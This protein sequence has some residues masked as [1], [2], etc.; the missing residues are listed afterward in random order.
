MLDPKPWKLDAV[1]RL[2][3]SVFICIFAGSLLIGVVHFAHH[4]SKGGL[5]F[6]PAVVVAFGFLAAT[7]VLIR[8]RWTLD[9]FMRRMT[10]LLVCF[11]AGLFLGMWAQQLA[12]PVRPDVPTS[13]QMLVTVLS[14][15]GAAILFIG[16]FLREHQTSWSEGFGLHHEPMKALLLGILAASLFLPLGWRLQTASADWIEWV[17]RHLHS[18]L[19]NLPLK[20]Q[21]Q[22]PVQT[23]RS[24]SSW[25]A[26]IALGVVTIFLVPVAEEILFRGIIYPWIKQRGH[27]RLA[28]VGTSVLFAAM[29]LNLVTFIPLFALAVVLTFLYEWTNNLLAPI[30]AHALFNGLNF[31]V[32]FIVESHPLGK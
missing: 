11:Y 26:R 3:I 27:P 21:E 17:S 18:A 22:L 13:G 20:V 6:Y 16:L 8:R 10:A 24:A 29:H 15:Q 1:V 5:K 4:G 32:L 23:L 14:F 28:L 19:P 2:L 25:A 7:L 30:T 9:N 12:W 31:A